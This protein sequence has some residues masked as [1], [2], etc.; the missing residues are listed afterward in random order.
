MAK[1][2]SITNMA[3]ALMHDEKTAHK[4]YIVKDS[5][6]RAFAGYPLF[7][8]FRLMLCFIVIIALLLHLMWFAFVIF[9]VFVKTAFIQHYVPVFVLFLLFYQRINSIY[10]RFV[11]NAQ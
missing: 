1:R 6:N 8:G 4:S 9:I 10:F 2:H 3:S 7:K 5:K 11:R